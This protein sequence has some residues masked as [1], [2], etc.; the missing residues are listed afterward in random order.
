MM[1]VYAR[2]TSIPGCDN[3]FKVDAD[4][5]D[6][7]VMEIETSSGRIIPILQIG[8]WFLLNASILDAMPQEGDTRRVSFT[9][10]GR[11][12]VPDIMIPGK[13]KMW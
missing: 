4:D 2:G 7:L 1:R 8:E 12:R 13:A 3:V 5:Y 11:Y 10:S 6:A 9:Y